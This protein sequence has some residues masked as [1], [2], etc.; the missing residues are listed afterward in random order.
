[1]KPEV[2]VRQGATSKVQN[3]PNTSKIIDA[4][5]EC[6]SSHKLNKMNKWD[7]HKKTHLPNPRVYESIT[8]LEDCGFVE[9]VGQK[10]VRNRLNSPTYNLTFK[11][12]LKYLS[13][14]ELKD[15]LEPEPNEPLDVWVERHLKKLY[16]DN[17]RLIAFLRNIGNEFNYPIFSE[18]DWLMK[19]YPHVL[20][21]ILAGAK[22]HLEKP[23]HF[24]FRCELEKTRKHEIS[25]DLKQMEKNQ[26]LQDDDAIRRQEAKLTEMSKMLSD[27]LK[28]EN[29]Y[30]MEDFA[31][32]FLSSL[33]GFRK[34]T[35][36][37]NEPLAK[38]ATTILEQR[39]KGLIPL[40]RTLKMFEM[41]EERFG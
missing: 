12:A 4:I 22:Y 30:L 13:S 11:G 3:K 33:F 7:I 27:S 6:L 17:R 35:L 32:Q 28:S 37:K 8:E 1:M 39:R 41:E 34:Y 23:S 9:K 18:I 36:S 29:S 2:S 38:F 15:D 26:S 24:A 40:E 5:A 21:N 19:N 20:P 16:T 10:K 31:F 14:T 25:D